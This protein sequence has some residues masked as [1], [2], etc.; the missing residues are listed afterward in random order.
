MKPFTLEDC[1]SANS[2]EVLPSLRSPDAMGR[3]PPAK[4]SGMQASEVEEW[5]VPILAISVP[6][7]RLAA[8]AEIDPNRRRQ[9]QQRFKTAKVYGD[10]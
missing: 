10:W 6:K 4:P 7:E 3:I 8:V 2:E 5:Q 9:A 1:L